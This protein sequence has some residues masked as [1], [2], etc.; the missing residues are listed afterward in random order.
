MTANGRWRGADELRF[1]EVLMT[2]LIDTSGGPTA[3]SVSAFVRVVR[4]AGVQGY[5]W[6]MKANKPETVLYQVTP[7]AVIPH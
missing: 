6:L 4:P 7:D 3:P 2:H 1:D 5:A